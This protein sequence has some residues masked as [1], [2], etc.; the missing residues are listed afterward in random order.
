MSFT[1]TPHHRNENEDERCDC[2][3]PQYGKT[4][5]FISHKQFS[6]IKVIHHP[7]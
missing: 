2:S 6:I 1:K 5:G 3:V 4:V 7:S